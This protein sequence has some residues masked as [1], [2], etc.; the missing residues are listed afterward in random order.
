MAVSVSQLFRLTSVAKLGTLTLDL[1]LLYSIF[2][3]E[4]NNIDPL[5]DLKIKPGSVGWWDGC[6]KA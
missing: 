5:L 6:E 4:K 1:S 3:L 2:R